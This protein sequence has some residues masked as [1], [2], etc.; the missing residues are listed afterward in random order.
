LFFFKYYYYKTIRSRFIWYIQIKLTKYRR[1]V[2]F[3]LLKFYY[4]YYKKATYLPKLEHNPSNSD[5]DRDNSD[6]KIPSLSDPRLETYRR[7]PGRVS[8][9]VVVWRCLSWT[10]SSTYF[11][12]VSSRATASQM[13]VVSQ[14]LA[15]SVH[16]VKSYLNLYASIITCKII[17]GIYNSCNGVLRIMSKDIH[18]SKFNTEQFSSRFLSLC[19]RRFNLSY[20]TLEIYRINEL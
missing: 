2:F 6:Y 4:F 19:V 18:I 10:S 12:I 15:L 3:F 5:M 13:I 11:S 9:D 20:A 7:C 14:A 16:I 1:F 8:C 17:Y